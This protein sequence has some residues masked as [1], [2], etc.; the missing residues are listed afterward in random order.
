MKIET[1]V[2]DDDGS[3]DEGRREVDH[4]YD[5]ERYRD[6]DDTVEGDNNGRDQTNSQ[7][8]LTFN[9][10]EIVNRPEGLQQTNQKHWF[11]SFDDKFLKPFLTRNE[12]ERRH[13]GNENSTE[14]TGGTLR[15]FRTSVKD[16][17]EG[18]NNRKNQGTGFTQRNNNG[19]L[20]QSSEDSSLSTQ[21]Q[22]FGTTTNPNL[23]GLQSF[24][25]FVVGDQ[26]VMMN[27]T[28]MNMF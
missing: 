27:P 4:H 5:G 12:E 9:S 18:F 1:G 28:R 7:G 13:E 10:G 25:D 24:S 17:D 3:D 14:S 22:D 15:G 11:I 21:R 8:P 16:G 20:S 23:N 2:E 26:N 6:D 19:N